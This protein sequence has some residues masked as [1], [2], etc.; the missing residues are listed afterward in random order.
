MAKAPTTKSGIPKSM[1]SKPSKPGKKNGSGKKK[2]S[3]RNC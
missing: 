1:P 3:A 2:K